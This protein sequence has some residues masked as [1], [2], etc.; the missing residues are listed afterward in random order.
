MALH[1]D[2]RLVDGYIIMS[3]EDEWSCIHTPISELCNTIQITGQM[4]F[5]YFYIIPL[6]V[7]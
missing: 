2:G 1:N 3:P 6:D 5:Y 4:L 7:I